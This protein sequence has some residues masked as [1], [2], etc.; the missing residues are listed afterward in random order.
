VVNKNIKNAVLIDYPGFNLSIA[1][2]LKKIGTRIIYYV[3]PQLWAWG[4][5]RINKIKNLVDKMLVVFPFEE[6]LYD[7]NGI[8]VSFVGHPLI[9]RINDY[10]FLS[11]EKL[12]NKF[13][14]DLSKDILLLMPGSRKQE[15]HKILPVTFNAAKKLA[16]EYNLQTVISCSNNLDEN[17]FHETCEDFDIKVAKGHT[18]D[19]MK[20]SRFGIVKSGTSTLEAGYFEI[21]MI[22]V[23]K[24]SAL[25]YMIGRTLVKVDKIGMV[26]I[27]LDD[28]VVPELIQNDV[29]QEN[30][31]ETGKEILG[32]ENNYS[33]IKEKLSGIK[34]KLGTEGASARAA[35]YINALM[36]ET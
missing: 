33:L 25:S 29:T 31:Y 20:Q 5:G 34:N 18:Y 2:K 17:L 35:N 10:Q 8:D 32:D 27:L 1:K 19:L 14:L 22:V 24:T 30:I 11:R 12:F 21:P 36:D 4:S 23:Y 16:E 13:Q 9:E 7:V 6:Q 15:V 3:S 28:N 26:N